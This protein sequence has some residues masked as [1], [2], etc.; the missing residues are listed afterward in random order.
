MRFKSKSELPETSGGNDFFKMKDGETK[1]I[2]CVGDP[3]EYTAAWTG[4]GFVPASPSEGGKFR[5]RINVVEKEGSAYVMRV[6]EQ[7]RTVYDDLSALHDEY[8]LDRTLLKVTRKGST[9]DDTSYNIF[10]AK[11]QLDPA[12]LEHIKTIKPHDLVPKGDHNSVGSQPPRDGSPM[13]G[14]D[15]EIPF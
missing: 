12:T 14:D 10:P 2:L 3:Y 4:K 5:F 11:Q 8:G 1:M 15:D 9:K 6:W 13:P 7:G